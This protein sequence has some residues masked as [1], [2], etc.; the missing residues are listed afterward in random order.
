MSY[1][2]NQMGMPNFE[3]ELRIS[4]LREDLERA[5]ENRKRRRE[6]EREEQE[7]EREEQERERE[8]ERQ[9]RAGSL[10]LS[11][12]SDDDEN[13]S[14]GKS[15]RS[16]SK[17]KET[18][19]ELIARMEEKRQQAF[20]SGD[21]TYNNQQ[22]CWWWDASDD[23]DEGAGGAGGASAK[24]AAGGASA[25]AAAGGGGAKAAAGGG[26]AKAAA[27][28]AGGDSGSDTTV[29]EVPPYAYLRYTQALAPGEEPRT[30]G[31]MPF[32]ITLKKPVVK[33]GREKANKGIEHIDQPRMVSRLHATIEFRQEEGEWRLYDKQSLNGTLLK[34]RDSATAIRVTEA[35]LKHGDVITF[36][37]AVATEVGKTPAANAVQSIYSYQFIM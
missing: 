20:L 11:E 34:S 1:P 33:L 3:E 28:A 36:G 26:G 30:L 9:K 14:S 15:K 6:R 37:G 22:A 23:D 18:R 13:G 2:Q 25:K 29:D 10:V 31:D 21:P 17:P 35:S 27:G 8:R 5:E 16:F 4:A 12:E 24:A 32:I 19:A 7:R